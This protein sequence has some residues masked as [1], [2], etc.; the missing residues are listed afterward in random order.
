MADLVTIK[1]A[2]NANVPVLTD[3]VTDGTLGTGQAQFLKILDGT[4]NSTNKAVVDSSGRLTVAPQPA[5]VIST[6]NSSSSTLTGGAAFTGTSEDV[7]NY[8]QIFV[9]VFA[10]HASA[11]DGLSLQ[12]SSNG[13]NWD[14]VDTYTI[15][16]STGR[17]FAVNP[18]AQFFRLVYTNGGTTQTAFRL[19]TVYKRF[20]ALPSS[21]R[22]GDAQTNDQDTISTQGFAMVWNGTTCASAT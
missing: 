21:N 9:T 14:I 12:Q 22:P 13:T 3:E 18:A 6:A 5:N 16:A 11:T 20:I 15:P 10:S 8:A 7:S 4:L 17:I 2:S 1:D 19:Q